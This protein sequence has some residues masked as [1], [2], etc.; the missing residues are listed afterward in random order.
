VQAV[1]TRPAENRIPERRACNNGAAA[2]TDDEP[3]TP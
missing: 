1:R 2:A 3:R